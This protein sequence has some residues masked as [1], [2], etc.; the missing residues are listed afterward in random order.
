M[1]KKEGTPKRSARKAIV[2][3][4]VA[5]AKTAKN[6]AKQM[7]MTGRTLPQPVEI[8]VRS[9][10][11]VALD[12]LRAERAR[13]VDELKH[14]Q[15]VEQEHPTTANHMAHDATEAPE[16]AKTLALRRHLEGM[17]KEIDRAM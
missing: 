11:V 17:L 12:R 14:Q 2:R 8:E 7:L 16:Q 13:L 15:V 3:G 9:A 5:A 6:S 10:N 1:S 4:V